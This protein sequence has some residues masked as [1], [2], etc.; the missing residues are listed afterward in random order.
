[1]V[2]G[3]CFEF[4]F[5]LEYKKGL[6]FS[7]Y[8]LSCGRYDEK[9]YKTQRRCPQRSWLIFDTFGKGVV[10]VVRK[11]LTNSRS[12]HSSGIRFRNTLLLGVPDHFNTSYIIS[13]EGGG[14]AENGRSILACLRSAPQMKTANINVETKIFA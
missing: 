4:F 5:V 8:G 12:I 9:N 13:P 14:R 6:V 1:M 3:S 11:G 2:L 10:A 7:M